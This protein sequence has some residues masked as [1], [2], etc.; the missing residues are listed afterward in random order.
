MQTCSDP[1][2]LV[3]H[4]PMSRNDDMSC[5][6]QRAASVVL[7]CVAAMVLGGCGSSTTTTTTT[8]TTSSA[9]TGSSTSGGSQP[10][11]STSGGSTTGGSTTGGSTPA[12]STVYAVGG[13]VSG[14]DSNESVTL[15]N[16]AEDAVVVSGNGAFTFPT[17]LVGGSAY[18]VTVKSHTPAIACSVAG[19]SGTVGAADV[20]GVAVSCA[21]GKLTI[22]YSFAGGASGTVPMAGLVM[23]SVGNLYG[24]TQQGGQHGNGTVFKLSASGTE[25]VLHSFGDTKNDG[26][27]PQATLVADSAGNLYGTTPSGGADGD[28]TIF[29]VAVNGDETVLYSFGGKVADGQNPYAG[30]VMDSAGNLYGTTQK[31]GAYA[32][33]TVFELSAG[34]AE[35]VL[36][37]F[38]ALGLGSDGQNPQGT[39]IMDGAG[40]LYGTTPNGGDGMAGTVFKVSAG[41]T[42]TILYSFDNTTKSDGRTPNAGVIMDNAGNLYGTTTYG[43]G[44]GGGPGDG[45][46]FTLSADGHESVLYS[47]G[48]TGTDGLN[49]YASLVIDSDGNLFGTT[50]QGG[51]YK[52]GGPHGG[53]TVF[54]LSPTGKETVL[55]SFGAAGEND[56]SLPHAELLVDSIGNLY[57]TT[58]AGGAHGD[59]TVFKI[60]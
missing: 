12:P 50:Q 11:G 38:Y 10:G 15:L 40:N 60:D 19:G 34:G 13:T 31:G 51:A 29:K 1:S 57:G 6:L 9:G 14:L 30:L 7:G 18:A 2:M 52:S 25:S 42:E 47:F 33:G 17:R 3:T 43:G 5:P 28:G 44:N 48:G 20:T 27:R 56:G 16:N 46:A 4:I 59:G 49:P 39:L 35:T 53:G 41:G 21:P 32:A 8:V 45:T 22:L 54:K 26:Q 37:S 24:T 23:D 36:H 58:A 55:Y